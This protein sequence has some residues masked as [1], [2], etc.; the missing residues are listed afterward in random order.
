M[1]IEFIYEENNYEKYYCIC[2][3][4]NTCS[5]CCGLHGFGGQSDRPEA[6]MPFGTD[7][8]DRA[9]QVSMQNTGHQIAI[10]VVSEHSD[11][12]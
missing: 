11:G 8:G 1:G 12:Q 10:V 3:P 6:E 2:N 5:Y 4:F 7:I 9:G